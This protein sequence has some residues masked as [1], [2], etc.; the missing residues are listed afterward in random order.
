MWGGFVS[1]LQQEMD[2][3]IDILIL[4]K[5]E[6]IYT[7][8]SGFV[9]VVRYFNSQTKIVSLDGRRIGRG[10]N[11]IP[12]PRKDLFDRLSIPLLS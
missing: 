2:A 3:L 6:L 7:T 1:N 9:D 5:A 12:I 11:N 4:A 10:K 8:G